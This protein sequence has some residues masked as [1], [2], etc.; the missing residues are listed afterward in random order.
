MLLI[1]TESK[2]TATYDNIEE[3]QGVNF[4]SEMPIDILAF[5]YAVPVAGGGILGY[6]KSSEF[7]FMYI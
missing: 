3:T 6:V 7:M 5:A 4:Y 2:Y 1:L